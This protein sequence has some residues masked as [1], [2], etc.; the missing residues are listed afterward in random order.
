[1]PEPSTLEAALL[2][3]DRIEQT[4]RA[5]RDAYALIDQYLA[6]RSDSMHRLAEQGWTQRQ[7]AAIAG[8]DAAKV[9]RILNKG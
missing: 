8:I 1:M 6:I 7:I 2:P 3:E 9:N 5:L 4:A